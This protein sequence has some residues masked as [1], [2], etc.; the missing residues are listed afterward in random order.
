[1]TTFTETT[2]TRSA[3]GQEIT[4]MLRLAWPIVLTNMAQTAMT[5]TDIMMLGWHG[6]DSLA[7]GALGVNLYYAFMISGLGVVSA[8]A[9]MLAKEIGENRFAV[10]ELRRT[11]RQGLW[12]AAM[13]ALPLWIILSNATGLLLG[14]GQE[15]RLATLAGDYVFLLQWGLL[16]FYGYIVLRS[17]ISA[18]ERPGWAL[19]IGVLAVGFNALANYGLIFGNF[20]L[21]E[22][23][24]KGSGLATSLS[25]LFMFAGLALV[26]LFDRKFRRYR[27][28]GRFWRSDWPR[29][30]QVWKLGIPIG[31]ILLF[32]VVFFTGA[33]LVMGLI[34]QP[35]IAAYQ[36]AIQIASIAFMVPLGMGQAATVRVGIA[37]GAGDPNGIRLAGN[38]AFWLVICFMSMTAA[39]MFAVPQALASVFIDASK[40]GGAEVMALSVSFLG[41]A[42][43]FQLFDGA[44]GVT[45]GM[46]RGLQDTK[47][48]MLFAGFG[49]WLI[50]MPLGIWLAFW[51]GWRGAGIWVG[52]TTGLAI[53][54]VL[55]IIRWLRRHV[56][57][58]ESSPAT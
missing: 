46:L 25:S 10:R 37:Y 22:M 4:A 41:F 8:V 43:M 33:A 16:P 53:V 55:V 51:Q 57:G 14:I 27:L 44:Q 54:S 35:S 45:L 7:A 49:Y 39:M 24:I 26:L 3:L 23:G 20:G 58:L 1:M 50:G 29:F 36:I 52:L 9:P 56:L 28:F 18:L 30:W 40:P 2:T 38:V 34:D 17:F 31:A 13:L 15:P 48:P 12:I 5:A 6:A 19:I 47:V 11:V 42:A 21:P 32:E